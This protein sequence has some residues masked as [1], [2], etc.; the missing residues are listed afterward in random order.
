MKIK[1]LVAAS[2]RDYA[3]HLSRVLSE[4]HTDTFDVSICT[5]VASFQDMLDRR[6]FDVVLVDEAF[7]DGVNMNNAR[8]VLMLWD[9]TQE[10]EH[11][12]GYGWLKKYQRISSLIGG[13]F[14]VYS[15]ISQN[16]DCSG[17]SKSKIISVWSPAGGVGKTTAALAYAAR[18]VADGKS[19]IYLNLENF[20][21][22]P[23]YFNNV[24]KSISSAFEKLDINVALY[25]R[26]ISKT[27]S[28]SGITYFAAPT[29][30]DDIN[31]LTADDMASLT[32][33]CAS[34][35]DELVVDL[36]SV[37]D[38]RVRRV[39][40]ISDYVLIVVDGSDTSMAK[41]RQFLNQHNVYDRIKEKCVL[42]SNKGSNYR[43]TGIDRVVSLPYVQTNNAGAVY[44]SL[45]ANRFEF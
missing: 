33:A 18:K 17:S 45:S 10:N 6:C 11:R 25:L 32:T 4:K 12:N 3:E 22:T 29:N 27:D 20:S 43:D 19:S 2:E 13:I 35:A 39:F 9:I 40:D 14:E 21:S 7:C 16:C 30:Y 1:L 8:L 38:E 41:L 42:V 31:I 44:K 36:P 34:I 26:G 24:S 5:S 23:V 37:C 15:E 28:D